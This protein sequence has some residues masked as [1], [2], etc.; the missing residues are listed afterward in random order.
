MAGATDLI[1][2]KATTARPSQD[3]SHRLSLQRIGWVG[4]AANACLRCGRT[5]M[6]SLVSSS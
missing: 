1:G 2:G 4:A 3:I 6:F 5:G